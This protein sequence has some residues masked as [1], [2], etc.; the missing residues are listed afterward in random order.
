MD[1]QGWILRALLFFTSFLVA[2]DRK[3]GLEAQALSSVQTSV[4]QMSD[5]SE[6]SVD[7]HGLA[8]KIQIVDLPVPL[9]GVRA[10]SLRGPVDE[11]SDSSHSNGSAQLNFPEPEYESVQ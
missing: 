2:Y 3:R 9:G 6:T 5:S 11:D 7:M 1:L 4:D 10:I 8:A